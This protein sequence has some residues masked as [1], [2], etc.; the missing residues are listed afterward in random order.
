[1][2][3]RFAAPVA[4]LLG[5]GLLLLSLAPAAA[6]L[7]ETKA[8]Q[9]FMIDAETGTV[10]FSKDADKPM[11]PASLAKLMTM[12][13]VFNAIKS[14]RVTLD[15]TFA[16]S[17]NAW[18]TGGAPSGTSTMF[19]KLKSTIRLEDLIQ[20]VTIQAANDGCIII[21]EGFAGSEANFATEMTNRARQIGLAK[22]TFVNSTGLPAE[23][24]Q[25]TVRELALLALHIWR[26]YPDF[27]RY[28]GQTD[29]TWNKITQR[30]RNPLLAMD[31]GADGLAVGMSEASGFGI[32]GSVSH[33]GARI[34]AAMSGLKSDRERAEEARKLLDWGVRAFQKTEIFA[35]DEV[36]G[37]AQVFGGAKSGVALKA[38]GP[39]NTFLPI[40]NRDKLTAK[41][42]YDGPVAA[43][44]EEGQP[45]GALRVWIGDTLSQETPLF[46]AESVGVGSL[47][48][49]ALDAVKELAVGWLR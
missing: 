23:G 28:Y 6:Q 20:G 32:V 29:F 39:V 35:K 2:K 43:P 24:Q 38:K 3:S 36:V 45:V 26:E 9:A 4:G 15:D 5:F 47:P 48:R 17:E 34:I 21:A 12:E 44:V 33:N 41:I 13:V 25:T 49:R 7:F 27:Y 30:N 22:S 37:E 31:I 19:A 42:V 14:G 18:R 46:A 40:A 1:M 10:L 11:P 16:V 8:A